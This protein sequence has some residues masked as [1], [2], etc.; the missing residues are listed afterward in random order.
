MSLVVRSLCPWP[1]LVQSVLPWI[2]LCSISGWD[3]MSL[4]PSAH[5]RGYSPFPN[6]PKPM[7]T[8]PFYQPVLGSCSW[9]V[10]LHQFLYSVGTDWSKCYSC[11]RMFLSLKGNPSLRQIFF[12]RKKY[13]LY[14]N[15]SIKA[16]FF[17]WQRAP[18]KVFIAQSM[19]DIQV[20]NNVLLFFIVNKMRLWMTGDALLFSW[21][22]LA[23]TESWAVLTWRG[24]IC[25]TQGPP[26]HWRR[27][28]IRIR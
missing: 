20:W 28:W 19:M 15:I 25:Q 4:H 24:I 8:A 12:S 22:N 3:K 13:F 10:F 2:S 14:I 26:G 1:F 11:N 5:H 7:L 23:E 18:T 9:T 17:E 27:G 16:Q 6:V 21:R